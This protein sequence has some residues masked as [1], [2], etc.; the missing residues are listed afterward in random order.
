MT[1]MNDLFRA[2]GRFDV[3][4]G[5]FFLYSELDAKD[6]LVTG[7]V[8]P[9]FKDLKVYDKGQDKS[10]PLVGKCTSAS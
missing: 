7:Y 8:K 1:R 6:G 4:A 9:L 5:R 10:K 3:S 2:Y